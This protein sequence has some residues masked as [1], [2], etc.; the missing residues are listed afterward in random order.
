MFRAFIHFL[1]AILIKLEP[2]LCN[3]WL[4][5]KKTIIIIK[6][7]PWFPPLKTLHFPR[8]IHFSR[9]SSSPL[10]SLSLTFKNSS[11]TTSFLSHNLLNS[12][13]KI[14]IINIKDW[15]LKVS[16]I[17]LQRV[18]SSSSILVSFQALLVPFLVSFLYLFTFQMADTFF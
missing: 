16:N 12:S 8:Y 14:I 17:I 2:N 11:F 3:C 9:H 15:R 4:L 18:R 13:P 1:I 10:F 6:R 7:G 5:L